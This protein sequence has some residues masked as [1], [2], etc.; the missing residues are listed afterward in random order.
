M[1]LGIEIEIGIARVSILQRHATI[2]WQ[3]FPT[4]QPLQGFQ[5]F[6]HFH[7]FGSEY[8][9]GKREDGFQIPDHERADLIW[10]KDFLKNKSMTGNFLENGRQGRK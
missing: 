5:C 1:D 7:K 9:G 8:D 10:E 6:H 3:P 4:F 2:S